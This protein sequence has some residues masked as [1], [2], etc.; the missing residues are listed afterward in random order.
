M[1]QLATLVRDKIREGVSSILVPA[2]GTVRKVECLE[3]C[4]GFVLESNFY[5]VTTFERS[6]VEAIHVF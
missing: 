6:E 2:H 1:I 3:T 4:I 5:V